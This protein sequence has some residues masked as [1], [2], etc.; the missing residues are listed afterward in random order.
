MTT[1]SALSSL[2]LLPRGAVPGLDT[3]ALME[4]AVIA[5]ADVGLVELAGPGAVA[6]LQG[7]LTND[8]ERSGDAAFV[9]GALLTAKGM[10]Q[11]DLWALRKGGAVILVI[12]RE[13]KAAVDEVLQKTVPPRL[14][15]ATER[16]TTAAWRLLGPKAL[17]LAAGVGIALPEPGHSGATLVRGAAVV[18]ARPRPA[19]S[20]ALELHL[21]GEHARVV[22]DALVSAGARETGAEVLELARILAGWPRLGAEIDSK[23]LPQE[24]RYDEIDGVSYTKGCYTGQET[25]ARVHFRGHPNRILAGLSWSAAPDFATSTVLQ[26]GREIGWVTSAAWLDPAEQHIGLAKVRREVDRRKPVTACGAAA[27]L[28]D[29]PFT[30]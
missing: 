23:T 25:V 6:C 12:P 28:A 2:R 13:G 18:A 1:P 20:F 4:G 19:A 21:E 11:S 8:V 15:R 9:Y 10:I 7:L 17:D 5:R 22:V 26:D 30:V 27:R 16:P 14:A 24:V 29:L 3:E